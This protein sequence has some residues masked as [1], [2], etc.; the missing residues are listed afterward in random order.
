MKL[1]GCVGIT[2]AVIWPI[3][4][5]QYVKNWIGVV[6]FYLAFTGM[7]LGADPEGFT[8][9]EAVRLA[10][11]N[12]ERAGVATARVEAAQARVA[13]A[14]AFFF[15]DLTFNGNYT[16][17][18]YE[19]FRTVDG[20]KLA[21]QRLN[22]FSS[23]T[24]VTLPILDAR[25]I[26]LY[27]QA[28]RDRN[29]IRLSTLNE[30]RLLAFDAA[31][32]FLTTLGAE[33][34]RDAAE[35]RLDLARNTLSDATVRFKAQ[36]V[37]SNDVTR[38]ELE[39][40]TAEREL[41]QAQGKR[42]AAY[43]FLGYLVN[44]EIKKPLVPPASL[45]QAASDTLNREMALVDQAQKRRLDVISSL[46]R[47]R[48]LKSFST[49]ALL[50]PLPR[51]GFTGQYRTTNEGGLSNRTRDWFLG[52]GLTWEL[53]DG[54]TWLAER[55]ERRAL[56]QEADLNAQAQIRRVA[57]DVQAAV[58]AL[59]SA[60][61]TVRQAEV[62]V[63]VAQRNARQTAELYRSGLAGALEVADANLRL[64]E[65][66]VALARG[67]YGLGLAFLDLRAALGLNAFGEEPN[68]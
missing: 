1:S 4:W 61:A 62:A 54:G 35:R 68:I 60:Q 52:L 41:T 23:T 66:D 59:E 32:A 64:F 28:T 25:S 9:E 5:C 37:S 13:R 17:R 38:A 39:L 51:L 21:V 33:Q 12:N 58:V 18:A 36:L 47:V 22:A 2:K 67:R 45:L 44:A 46:W 57:L 8:L 6:A 43:L 48:A 56:V 26:P 49:E 31:A 16:R 15:P 42:D 65:A 14:Q 50:R 27:Q 63:V 55:R 29:A 53:L 10:G 7:A 24:T 19:T 20:E 11:M 30:Q 40:A 34:V 3:L